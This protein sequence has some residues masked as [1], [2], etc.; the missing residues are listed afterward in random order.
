MG[1]VA[2]ADVELQNNEDV[3]EAKHGHLAPDKIRSITL[4]MVAD[5]GARAV[6]LPMPIIQSLGLPQTRDVTVTL[7]SGRKEKRPLF[8]ELRL[9]IGDRES[10][11]DCIGKPD[12]APC[13]LGQ[14][15]FEALDLVVDCPNHRVTTNPEAPDG[16]MLYDDY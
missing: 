8:G 2:V 13:L 15:V 3:I 10:V 6:G 5:T 1:K 9:R 11:F 14:L 7:S 4:E 12:D 16:M